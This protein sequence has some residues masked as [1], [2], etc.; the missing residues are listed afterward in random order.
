MQLSASAL[1]LAA[2]AFAGVHAQSGS[3]SAGAAPTGIAG[4]SPCILQCITQAATGTGCSGLT[5]VTCFCTN[6]QFQQASAACLQQSCT[7]ADLQTVMALQQS[8]CANVSASGSGSASAPSGSATAPATSASAS[9]AAPTSSASGASGVSGASGASTTAPAAS[10][11][12][13][14]AGSTDTTAPAATT[15]TTSNAAAALKSGEFGGLLGVG[16]ALVG[17]VAGAAL[18]L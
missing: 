8:E 6:T 16:V 11:S 1:V 18:L 3:G 2:A 9:G 5:D 4:I 12:G 10:T 15:S 17:A 14:A 7:A 13:A